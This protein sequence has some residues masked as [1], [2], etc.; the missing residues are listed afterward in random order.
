MPVPRR[1]MKMLQAG[2]DAFGCDVH[3]K[4]F[5]QKLESIGS[6]LITM[7]SILAKIQAAGQN[8]NSI[9]NSF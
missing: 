8:L 4:L 6:V 2:I 3:G 1:R 5:S 7:N 9:F